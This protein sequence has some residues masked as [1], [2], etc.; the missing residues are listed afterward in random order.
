[1]P[2]T[3]SLLILV[4]AIHFLSA[5]YKVIE[6]NGDRILVQFTINHF[7]IRVE[8]GVSVIQTS[9]MNYPM[10]AGA[11]AIPY[12]EWKIGVPNGAALSVRIV[13]IRQHKTM[14][15]EIMQ[16]IPAVRT[17]AGQTSYDFVI[18]EDM[19]RL[20]SEPTVKVGGQ[21]TFR[22]HH[23]IPVFVN[24]FQYDG[25][26]ELGVVQSMTVEFMI[27][28]NTGYRSELADDELS[29]LFLAG[30]INPVQSRQWRMD[31][32]TQINTASFSSADWWV[33][34][35]TD[36]QG[37]FRINPSNL[38]FLPLGDIDPRTF[39]LFSTGGALLPNTVVDTGYAFN[40]VPI[41]VM[42]EADGSFDSGD[43]IL[44]YGRDRNDFTI[45]QPAISGLYHNPYSNNV[46][47]WLTFGG[48]FTGPPL[49]IPDMATITT[50]DN[51]TDRQPHTVRVEQETHRRTIYGFD[52]YMAKFFG[53]N[54]A[55][56]QYQ[57]NLTD[58]APGDEQN[59]SFMIRQEDITA[60]FQH[61]MSV[62]VNDEPIYSNPQTNNA[63]WIWYGVSAF[64]FHKNTTLFQEGQNTIRFRVWRDR[65][66]NLFFDHYQVIY[67]KKLIKRN[68]QYQVSIPVSLQNANVRYMFTGSGDDVY[69]FKVEDFNLV[70]RVSVNSTGSGFNFVGKGNTAHSY[71]VIQPADLY[72]P[73]LIVGANPLDLTAL[74]QPIDNIIVTPLEFRS[75]A[76]TLADFYQVNYGVRSLVVDQNDLFTVF[77][78]GHPDPAAIKQFVRYAYHHYPQPR[79]TSM[80]LLG[81]GTID[82][83]NYSFLAGGKNRI[84]PYQKN[85]DVSDDYLGMINTS[86]YPE[87]V[88]GRYPVQNTSELDIM[89]LNMRNYVENPTPGLWRNSVLIVADDEFNAGATSEYMHTQQAQ[90]SG[91]T[92]NRGVLTDKLMAIEYAFDEFQNKPK[93]RDDLFASINDGKLVFYYIGHGA[94]DKLGSEDYLSSASDMN[95]FTNQGKLTLFMAASCHVGHFDYPGFESLAQK[96]LLMNNAGAIAS[97]AGTRE[98]YPVHN[99]PLFINVLDN[100]V[101][102]YNQ[103]GWALLNGKIS[104]TL[105]NNNDEKYALLGD[106][107]V[108]ITPPLRHS[109]ITWHNNTS[110]NPIISARQLTQFNGRFSHSSTNGTANIHVYDSDVY[111]IVGPGVTTSL[112]AP[113]TTGGNTFQ[114]WM[115]GSNI[116]STNRTIAI[117]ISSDKNLTAVYTSPSNV[118]SLTVRSL[119]P[120]SGVSVSVSPSDVNG[121]ADGVTTFI[122]FYQ[123]G[124]IVSLNAPGISGDR[125][126]QFWMD[127]TGI[128]SQQNVLEISID[129]DRAFTAVYYS[130]TGSYQLNVQS[131]DPAS[132]AVI[133]IHPPDNTSQ[134]D[135]TTPFVRIYPHN[136]QVTLI[137][138]QIAG[139]NFFKHWKEG[140]TIITTGPS[141][142]IPLYTNRT[143][144]AVYSIPYPVFR[145]AVAS[146][147]PN[148][149]V[150]I[151]VSPPDLT[152]QA[153]GTTPFTRKYN[154]GLTITARGKDLFRGESAVT[155]GQYSAGF[156]VPDD[157]SNGNRGSIV[158]YLWDNANNRD[159]ISYFYP[160][161][162]SNVGNPVSNPDA[163][164]IQLF[165]GSMDFRP[166]DTVTS[167]PMLYARISDSNGINLTGSPGHNILLILD[168]SS[169]PVDITPYF[170]YDTNS[171]TEGLLTYQLPTLTEGSHSIQLIAFDNFNLPAVANT[172]FIVRKSGELMIDRLLIYPNPFKNDANVT[173][174]LSKD[175]EITINVFTITGKRIRSIRAFGRQ[176]FNQIP[177]DGRDAEGNRLA[178]N[179]YFLKVKAIDNTNRSV[180]KVERFVVFK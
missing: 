109:D 75:R 131:S 99:I 78:G 144:T 1:M 139:N 159:Y 122:R 14:L 63:D 69:V 33:R 107:L 66:D 115:D 57:V 55:D 7:E 46:V 62:Y 37:M 20:W 41:L 82:W 67:N 44:F 17:E 83:K 89:L 94:Y 114:Y 160:I 18:N 147:N 65:A 164:E 54:S 93:V 140:D 30:V 8:N 136:T 35:E 165:I 118:Y 70:K 56:Y 138:A 58:I 88:I 137:A 116:V 51:E 106:P 98:T 26:R 79:L 174:I 124:T 173:F 146:L 74:N 48:S 110:A 104:Y 163:P 108:Y 120:S 169:Q 177:W 16:P 126:F 125:Q 96:V 10:P 36:R 28:G 123:S 49:R 127:G 24:P 150:A 13:E 60:N 29:R 90:D 154:Q 171:W 117:P 85:L 179:T 38:S 155:S 23:Y 103:I 111:R 39:R 68:A 135:G 156:I 153:S 19:Y 77:N 3:I 167:N 34:V 121:D 143:I 130:P 59:L 162:T 5:G 72:S 129:R 151:Q 141:V 64:N 92:I 2:K 22:S 80:T 53:S 105:G 84:M 133:S 97:I 149:G 43:Y 52:W 15:P 170:T 32:R 157:I 95:R 61:R 102:Q 40:E 180:E 178:N 73:V 87:I 142:T 81:L 25:D 42:G 152:G 12:E 134:N 9:G 71:H 166:G 47:Y 158:N 50:W 172:H 86:A 101:N 112:T 6:N 45:N 176:G 76:Q 148:E 91:E 27:N 132:G 4:L 161:T 31:L 113:Q 168:Q 145:V 119:D 175:A 11:P 21:N 128:I 100:A